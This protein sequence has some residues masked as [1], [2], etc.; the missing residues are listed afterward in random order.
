VDSNLAAA[1]EVLGVV[2]ELLMTPS[3]F[4]LMIPLILSLVVLSDFKKGFPR[5][6][7]VCRRGSISTT[8]KSTKVEESWNSINTFFAIP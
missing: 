1:H 3:N 7:K 4:M 6:M 2:D 8:M 5:M